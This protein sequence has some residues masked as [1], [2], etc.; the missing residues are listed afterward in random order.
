MGNFKTYFVVNPNSANGRTGK[1]WP[2]IKP[3]AESVLGEVGFGLTDRP[4]HAM[5][6]AREALKSGWEMIVSLGGDGTNNEVANGFFEDDKPIN[7]DAVMGVVCSGTGS[8]LIR[9]INVPRDFHESVPL[10]AGRD[11]R[12]TDVGRMTLRGHDG[13]DVVRYFINIASFGIGGEV[14]ELVNNSSK[15]LGGKASFLW[16]SVRG[17]LAYNNRSVTIRLDGG[18]LLERKVFN[19]VVANGQYFG[20][21]MRPAP[22]AVIDDGRFDV[23]IMGD[24]TFFEQLSLS[25][26]IYT[27][28]HLK[29]KK[30]ESFRAKKIEADS[31]ERVLLDVDGEQPGMLPASFEILPGAIRMKRP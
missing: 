29:M 1:L 25:R 18:E 19:A 24:F 28:E 23:V 15:L 10:L 9:T 16:A 30:V 12:P 21:A 31:S 3:L 6:L 17:T 4:M 26:S 27:G 14:D 2:E 22:D 13:K 7:P 8:D 20:A 5:E 11:A